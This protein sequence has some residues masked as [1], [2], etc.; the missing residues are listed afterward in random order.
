L[1][2]AEQ[3]R[4]RARTG[5]ATNADRKPLQAL[6]LRG[7]PHEVA[8][9]TR[10]GRRVDVD[11]FRS[12]TVGVCLGYLDLHPVGNIAAPAPDVEDDLALCRAG[13]EAEDVGLDPCLQ[14]TRGRRRLR[15]PSFRQQG[16]VATANRD[17]QAQEGTDPWLSFHMSPVSREPLPSTFR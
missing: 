17:L 5:I 13:F 2:H 7:S 9:G 12:P 15:R 6:P 1:A 11:A 8:G 16:R 4:D 3:Q 10:E 14:V